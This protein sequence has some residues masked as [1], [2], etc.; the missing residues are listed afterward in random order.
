MWL[1]LQEL[2]AQRETHPRIQGY[3]SDLEVAPITTI[4]SVFTPESVAAC[5][6]RLAQAQWRKI[7]SLG[8]TDLYR[9]N[10][11]YSI[12]LRCFTA[13]AFV[14]EAMVVEY[15]NQ[16]SASVP[17][18]APAGVLSFFEFIADT[19]VGREVQERENS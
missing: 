18:Y 1:K 19:Y 5:F 3:G 10:E 11:E 13:I 17:E 15:F 7:Q 9:E 4:I 12:F 6:F 2:M 8:L 16:L 14:P